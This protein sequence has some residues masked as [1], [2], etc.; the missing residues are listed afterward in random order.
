MTP[1]DYLLKGGKVIDPA[2][3]IDSPMDVAVKRRPDR[4]RRA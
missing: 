1:Y 4:R 2:N 3:N